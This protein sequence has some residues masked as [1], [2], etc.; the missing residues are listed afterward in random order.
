ML[1][2]ATDCEDTLTG[3]YVSNTTAT[4]RKAKPAGDEDRVTDKGDCGAPHLAQNTAGG[5]R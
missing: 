5:C 3:M 1:K 2:I 4:P